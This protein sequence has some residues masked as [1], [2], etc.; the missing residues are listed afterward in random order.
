[1]FLKWK[2]S[3]HGT[4]CKSAFEKEK[5]KNLFLW[6]NNLSVPNI[7]WGKYPVFPFS[8]APLLTE[9]TGGTGLTVLQTPA[10]AC[11]STSELP[12]VSGGK[13]LHVAMREEDHAHLL[14][15]W[16]L[17]EIKVPDTQQC[18]CCVT[19]RNHLCSQARCIEDEVFSRRWLPGLSCLP[20]SSTGQHCQDHFPLGGWRNCVASGMG[21]CPSMRERGQYLG[22]EWEQR[23]GELSMPIF[24]SVSWISGGG[25]E[26][27]HKVDIKS[28]GGFQWTQ[29]SLALCHWGQ[30]NCL[31]QAY[32]ASKCQVCM[33]LNC[34]MAACCL[35]SKQLITLTSLT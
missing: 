7:F 12:P 34:E 30:C 35:V 24:P 20:S 29:P 26:L 28:P 33:T 9:S 6:K 5:E 31:F 25:Q 10:I 14:L 3:F 15:P 23:K 17:K 11:E 13:Q 21:M 2:T 4:F 32:F 18:S 22:W 16:R 19:G 1:M 27:R 8:W